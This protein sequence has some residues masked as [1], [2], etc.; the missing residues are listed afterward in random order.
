MCI[1]DSSNIVTLR[2]SFHGRTVTT[3]AA[4]GQD[5]F[6]NYFFPFTEGFRL[7]LIHI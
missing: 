7:S 1:R 4:T 5:V 2:Q 6:H 3:L